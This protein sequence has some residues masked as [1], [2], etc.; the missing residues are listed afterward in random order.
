MFLRTNHLTCIQV[1][2]LTAV[3]S[4]S[5]LSQKISAP[6]RR[7]GITHVMTFKQ[8]S[9]LSLKTKTQKLLTSFLIYY[10]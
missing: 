5:P 10:N 6:H 1:K 3:E 7:A 8:M 4:A 2:K 9:T